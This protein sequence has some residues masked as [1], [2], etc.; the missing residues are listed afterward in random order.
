MSQIRLM[1][2]PRQHGSLH[3]PWPAAQVWRL[4]FL[5]IVYY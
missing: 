4:R 1:E 3:A 2:P 5:A